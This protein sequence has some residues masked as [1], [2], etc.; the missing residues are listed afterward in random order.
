[1]AGGNERVIYVDMTDAKGLIND[2]RGK[3]TEKEFETLMARSFKKTAGRVR[4]IL[5]EELP[6]D[7][8]VKKSSISRA[9]KNPRMTRTPGMAVSCC[10]PIEGVRHAIGGE[11]RASGGRYGWRGIQA[12]RRYQIKAS[13]LK[14]ARSTLPEEMRRMGG[15]PPF[16]NLS[17]RRLNNIAF[18]REGKDRLP[19]RPI[20]SIGIPQMPVNRSEDRVQN[21]IR[22][23]LMDRMEHEHRYMIGRIKRR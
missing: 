21:E 2:L 13:I 23:Y 6:K 1:M 16:R 4:R 22:E 20:Y 7:Y 17:A 15:K 9:V 10:I 14:K 3:H 11:F 8:H 19:I 5:R 18:T 12:G